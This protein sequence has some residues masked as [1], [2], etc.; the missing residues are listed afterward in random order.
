MAKDQWVTVTA[1]LNNRFHTAYGGRGPVL[2][3]IDVQVT[4]KP[5]QEVA[6]FF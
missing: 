4:Q 6:T 1:R 3:A 2:T 5:E